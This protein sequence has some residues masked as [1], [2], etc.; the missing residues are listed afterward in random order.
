MQVVL[1]VD[2]RK[3]SFFLELIKNFDFVSVEKTLSE[4]ELDDLYC[5][6]LYQDAVREPLETVSWQQ[7]RQ[8]L[9]LP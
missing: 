8:G 3:M 6:K 5:E 9:N 4:D 2:D 7:V 1:S